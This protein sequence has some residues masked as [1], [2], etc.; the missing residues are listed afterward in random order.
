M[1][2]SI[3]SSDPTTSARSSTSVRT[4]CWRLNIRSWRVR[5]AARIA[6]AW[7]S[8]MSW[9]AGCSPPTASSASSASVTMTARML[10]KSCATPPA[11]RP[12]AS[13]FCDCRSCSSS[14]RSSVTS[15]REDKHARR[16]YHVIG[17]VMTSTSIT[18]PS[19]RL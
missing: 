11:K 1:R 14:P 3:R 8:L 12:M 2:R 6:A 10:L 5:A 9:N 17:W 4:G 16:P 19:L 15:R 18:V 7:I 13:I